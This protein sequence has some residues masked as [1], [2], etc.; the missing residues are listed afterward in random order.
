MDRAGTNVL[1]CQFNAAGASVPAKRWRSGGKPLRMRAS[2]RPFPR[3]VSPLSFRCRWRRSFRRRRISLPD[4]DSCT[5]PAAPG[6]AV[7][8]WH[9]MRTRCFCIDHAAPG[10]H[11]ADDVAGGAA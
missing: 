2:G 6:S 10:A 8:G 3:T 7:T 5:P 11:G 9:G 1:A 4:R